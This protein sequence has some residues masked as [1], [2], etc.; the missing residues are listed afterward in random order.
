MESDISTGWSVFVDGTSNTKGS[1]VGLLLV[2]VY[3]L[4]LEV[5][6]RFEFPTSNNQEEYEA[7]LAGFILVFEMRVETFIINHIQT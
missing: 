5:A 6:I 4:I 1:G 2:N 3:K 7:C